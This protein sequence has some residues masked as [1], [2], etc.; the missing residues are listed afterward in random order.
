VGPTYPISDTLKVDLFDPFTGQIGAANRN[1]AGEYVF[2]KVPAGQW[3]LRL[4]PANGSVPPVWQQVDVSQ[5]AFVQLRA[6]Q[7]T[8]T[9]LSLGL[10]GNLSEPDLDGKPDGSQSLVAWVENDGTAKRVKALRL[11]AARNPVG[12]AITVDT[13]GANATT[14]NWPQDESV[15]V[16]YNPIKDEYAVAWWDATGGSGGYGNTLIRRVGTDGTLLGVL[17]G[18]NAKLA[19]VDL[20][21]NTSDGSYMLAYCNQ[22]LASANRF[23]QTTQLIVNA[24]GS[25]NDSNWGVSTELGCSNVSIAYVRSANRFALTFQKPNTDMDVVAAVL[26]PNGLS[27]A[28]YDGT[29][30]KIPVATGAGVATAGHVASRYDVTV[31][32]ATETLGE[33]LVTWLQQNGTNTEIWGRRIQV[34]ATGPGVLTSPVL[35]VANGVNGRPRQDYMTPTSANA[36]NAGHYLLT[37][38]HAGPNGTDVYA[39]RVNAFLFDPIDDRGEQAL[40]ATELADA[41]TRPTVFAHH[42]ASDYT[43][44]WQRANTLE[45]RVVR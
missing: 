29:T 12:S 34:S 10:S 9:P 35:L 16:T 7:Q 13:R 15:A 14:G 28:D 23:I 3:W 45:A 37:W 40:V 26:E 42:G 36:A 8:A 5:D 30:N 43:V 32:G 2:P 6:F 27:Y 33:V 39:R 38:E 31:A 21:C 20:A 4:S 24:D 25:W 11:D 41:D 19:Q 22:S 18:A 44:L 17:R 1:A